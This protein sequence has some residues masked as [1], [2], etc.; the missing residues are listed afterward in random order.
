MTVLVN[1]S[2]VVLRDAAPLSEESPTL[3]A[4]AELLVGL[5]V[6]EYISVLVLVS[7]TTMTDGDDEDEDAV[8]LELDSVMVEVLVT[9]SVEVDGVITT[10]EVEVIVIVLGLIDCPFEEDGL[11]G[12]AL[13]VSTL[14][15][16]LDVLMEV[17]GGF[18]EVLVSI[19]TMVELAVVGSGLRVVTAPAPG[20]K[21]IACVQIPSLL[22]CVEGSGKVNPLGR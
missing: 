10:V 12:T 22:S 5:D 9:T 16:T 3:E 8:E 20:F 19:S 21:V 15:I 2:V 1:V 17:T 7:I 11:G 6:V 13:L 14:T 18:S 4:A